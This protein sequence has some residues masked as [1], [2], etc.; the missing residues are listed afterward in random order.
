MKLTKEHMTLESGQHGE[1]L[2]DL[3]SLAPN[4]GDWGAQD[5]A[6]ILRHQLN[7]DLRVDLGKLVPASVEGQEDL[8]IRTF[9]ELFGHADPPIALLSAVKEFAKRQAAHKQALLPPEVSNLLYYLSI[10]LALL[11]HG[12][13]ISTLDNA[14][15]RRGLEWAVTQPWIES[16]LRGIITEAIQATSAM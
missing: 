7:A 9:A 2:S 3:M 10:G 6:A 11:R 1:R 5:L 8:G 4:I 14:A 15:L 16:S 12:K 13:L